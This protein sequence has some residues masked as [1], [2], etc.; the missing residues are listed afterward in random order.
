M[1]DNHNN[2]GCYCS[3]THCSK[4]KT[5]KRWEVNAPLGTHQAYDYSTTG[6]CVYR[7]GSRYEETWDCGDKSETYP[8]YVEMPITETKKFDKNIYDSDKFTSSYD[9]ACKHF[10]GSIWKH[11]VVITDKERCKKVEDVGVIILVVDENDIILGV[12]I[13]NGESNIYDLNW[14]KL[15]EDT[16]NSIREI[17]KGKY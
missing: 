17:N 13:G 9:N 7:G 11:R 14:R 4:K 1:N 15:N 3:G 2:F 16:W 10:F 5:C 8:L 6:S 12:K